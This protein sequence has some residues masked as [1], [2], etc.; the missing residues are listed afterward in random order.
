MS[1]ETMR[2]MPD[3]T[4][5]PL[6]TF[7]AKRA[8]IYW[9]QNPDICDVIVNDGPL[10][11]EVAPSHSAGAVNPGW[12]EP[13]STDLKATLLQPYER[14]PEGVLGML[15]ARDFS[16]EHGDVIGATLFGF[17]QID[18]CDWARRMLYAYKA[19][20]LGYIHQLSDGSLTT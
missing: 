7:P 15:L 14:T 4:A 13:E 11:A 17:S 20:A 18:E 2:Y 12:C 8:H 9:N 1:D 16:N 19:Q 6:T 3:G 5:Y 10:P